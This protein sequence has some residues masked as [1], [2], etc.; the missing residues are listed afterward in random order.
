[1]ADAS[2]APPLSRSA[3]CPGLSRGA[4]GQ[5]SPSRGTQLV[6]AG[7]TGGHHV[8]AAVE[9]HE[10]RLER[11]QKLMWDQRRR[12]EAEHR[13]SRR[14]MLEFNATLP[15]QA[16]CS[17]Y[18]INGKV[19]SSS[20]GRS[21]PCPRPNAAHWFMQ[22]NGDVGRYNIISHQPLHPM[23][24]G[25]LDSTASRFKSGGV[26]GASI[27]PPAAGQVLP[28]A[29]VH[30]RLFRHGATFSQARSIPGHTERH[31]TLYSASV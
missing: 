2:G 19:Y 11:S 25:V 22:V 29:P 26:G 18:E 30:A 20:V 16:P 13:G 9:D 31:H 14:S 17:T 1:M 3:S 12:V 10:G 6:C 27:G 5:G 15:H 4:A 21:P 23:H 8:W 7:G 28:S 24:T